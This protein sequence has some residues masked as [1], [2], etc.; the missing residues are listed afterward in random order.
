[1]MWQQFQRLKKTL[2]EQDSIAGA[3]S[4]E[5]SDMRRGFQKFQAIFGAGIAKEARTQKAEMSQVEKVG[6]R[7]AEGA[8]K[9]LMGAAIAQEKNDKKTRKDEEK[10]ALGG[11][12]KERKAYKKILRKK[13]TAW[14]K[15]KKKFEK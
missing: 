9:R 11:I 14:R 7:G 2:N 3:M 15:E 5:A 8:F 10:I 6:L 12:G 13:T 4:R 1:M